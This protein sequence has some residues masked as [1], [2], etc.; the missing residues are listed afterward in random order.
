M[1]V[2]I[3][4]KQLERSMAKLTKRQGEVFD[5]IKGYIKENGMPPTAVEI[6]TFF[7][8]YPNGA[9]LHVQALIKGMTVVFA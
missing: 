7:D 5:F 3:L 8:I 4:M 2:L 1:T 6:G 9:W